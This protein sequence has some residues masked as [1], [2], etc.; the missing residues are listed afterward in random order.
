MPT[1]LLSYQPTRLRKTTVFF[2]SKELFFVQQTNMPKQKFILVYDALCAW[3]KVFTPVVEQLLSEQKKAI[4]IQWISG[5]WIAADATEHWKKDVH[6]IQLSLLSSS[7]RMGAD[8]FEAARLCRKLEHVS[9]QNSEVPTKAMLVMQDEYPELLFSFLQKLQGAF[10]EEGAC[11]STPDGLGHQLASFPV[12]KDSFIHRVFSLETHAL[13][14][15]HQNSFELLG[16]TSFPTLLFET[17]DGRLHVLA[18][19]YTTLEQLRSKLNALHHQK[20]QPIFMKG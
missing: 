13:W 11:I 3:T 20:A 10:F 15:E 17:E 18:K 4:D 6:K 19:G 1:K 9:V 16:A 8:A 7:M 14:L 12:E 2:N 5:S